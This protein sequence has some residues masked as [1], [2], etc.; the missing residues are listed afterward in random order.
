[1][2]KAI[3]GRI[4]VMGKEMGRNP[5]TWITVDSNEVVTG[6]SFESV[7]FKIGWKMS[8]EEIYEMRNLPIW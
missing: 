7:L 1:M 4:T 6:E 3:M 5:R 2:D 8:D